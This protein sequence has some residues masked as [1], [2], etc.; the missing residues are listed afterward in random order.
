MRM[1]VS[2]LCQARFLVFYDNS[3]HLHLFFTTLYIS[4]AA[5][6]DDE[7]SQDLRWE[8]QEQL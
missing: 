1:R 4:P 3:Y 5:K 2:L 8:P 7:R 6:L